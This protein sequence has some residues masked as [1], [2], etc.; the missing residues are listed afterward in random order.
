[1]YGSKRVSSNYLAV[2]EI[3]FSNAVDI[4]NFIMTAQEYFSQANYAQVAVLKNQSMKG[5]PLMTRGLI[6]FIMQV[7]ING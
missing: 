7:K 3:R 5:D 2:A 1:M 4:S 6:R